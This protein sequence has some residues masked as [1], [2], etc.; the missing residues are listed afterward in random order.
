MWGPANYI[1]S[2]SVSS[3]GPSPWQRLVSDLSSLMRSITQSSS[4]SLL[5]STAL[6]VS[7]QLWRLSAV[8]QWQVC[9]TLQGRKGRR[10][11]LSLSHTVCRCWHTCE[12]EYWTGTCEMCLISFRVRWQPWSEIRLKPQ[13]RT[14]TDRNID[15]KH[16][17]PVNNVLQRAEAAEEEVYL[18]PYIISQTFNPETWSGKNRQKPAYKCSANHPAVVVH[19]LEIFLCLQS[20]ADSA[21]TSELSQSHIRSGRKVSKGVERGLWISFLPRSEASEYQHIKLCSLSDKKA[22]STQ[23]QFDQ[24]C[25]RKTWRWRWRR[26]SRGLRGDILTCG[27]NSGIWFSSTGVYLSSFSFTKLK[28]HH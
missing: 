27:V 26:C 21:E 12:Q 10:P 6:S 7:T 15:A 22:A 5:I 23:I 2:V 3:D 19:P 13:L 28:H 17:E 25:Q 16:T 9:D 24:S 18:N 14:S 8:P 1:F 11:V 20:P 4:S